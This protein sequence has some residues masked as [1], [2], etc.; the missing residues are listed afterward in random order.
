M[1]DGGFL[2]VAEGVLP[3]PGAVLVQPQGTLKKAGG[4]ARDKQ[5]ILLGFHNGFHALPLELYV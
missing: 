3:Q 2:V 5:E 1:F 4:I